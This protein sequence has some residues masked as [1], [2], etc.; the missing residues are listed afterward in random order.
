MK[1]FICWYAYQGMETEGKLALEKP[2]IINAVDMAEAMWNYHNILTPYWGKTFY[3]NDLEK[4]RSKGEFTGW[5][6]WCKEL[7]N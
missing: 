7:A 5:G 4:Y 3:D 2:E 1:T 6:F